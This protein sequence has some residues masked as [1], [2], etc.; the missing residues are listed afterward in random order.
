MSKQEQ[1][2]LIVEE[3]HKGGQSIRALCQ[4]NN[5]SKDSFYYWLEKYKRLKSC[6]NKFIP[7]N[8]VSPI[9]KSHPITITYPNKVSLT[10]EGIS[11]LQ[12]IKSLITLF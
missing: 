6:P 9:C 7:V 2:F 10:V 12:F 5:V 11:D 8:I 3:Y 4:K 1:M